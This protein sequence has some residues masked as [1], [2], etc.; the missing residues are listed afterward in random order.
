[1]VILMTGPGEPEARCGVA[2]RRRPVAQQR[3]HR[4]RN[5]G[6]RTR[7]PFDYPDDEE[8]ADN[9]G[10]T[11]AISW[12]LGHRAT[13]IELSKT[14]EALRFSGLLHDQVT[15]LVTRSDWPMRS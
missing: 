15:V 14:T 9:L 3:R 4:M 12:E 5:N 11:P 1:M 13:S 6:R 8:I 2:D 10:V 7:V